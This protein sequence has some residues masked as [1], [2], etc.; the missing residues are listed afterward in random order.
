[1]S[2]K[3]QTLAMAADQSGY[4]QYRKPT[5]RDE[6][7][8]TME[9]IVPWAALCEVIEPYY[10]KAGNGRPPIGLERMLRI[11]FIQHWFNL[12]DL[13]CEEAL[14]DSASLRR[15]VGIDLGREPVP[16]ATTLLK[17]RRLL[18]DNKL[19]EALFAKVGEELQARGF[20]VNTGTIVDATIIGAPS[21]TKNADRARDPEMHQTRKGQQWYFGMKLHIGVDSQTGLTH[22]AVVTAANVHDKHPL[23]DLLHGQERRVYGDSAYASQKNLI[24][25]KAPAARDF[26]NQRTRRNGIVDEALKSKN[27]NKSRIRSRVEHVFGV[28][29]RL[30]G[31]AKVRYRGLAKNATRAFTALALANIYLSRQRLMAQVRP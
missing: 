8:A 15:F 7:L 26:T 29:K 10:P 25:G 12:A 16:D 18:N 9:A 13:A 11:H 27:R 19:G 2:M 30:W 1:M 31:F 17:F 23:P 28:I 14:Y 6:F 20:K 21:S 24:E 22:S 5:R 4:E 3:Q